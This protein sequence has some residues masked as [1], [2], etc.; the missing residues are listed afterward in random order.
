MK[1]ITNL[2]NI[3]N[4]VKTIS[5][6]C[7]VNTPKILIVTKYIGNN[8]INDIHS[9]DKK[10]HFGENY[11]D[12]LIEK[13]EQL[14]NSIKWHFIG[15]LQSNKC[16]NILKV[17]NLYMIESID[18]EKKA[19]LLNNYL[20]IINEDNLNTNENL[21]KIR[22]LIQIKT[23]DDENKTGIIHDNYEEI[24]N[25]VLYII[26]N[27]NFLIF[28]GLMTISSLEIS[29]RENSFIILNNIK[30]RL[31]N[32]KTINNYFHKKKFHMSMG[33]SDDLELAIKHQTTQLRIGRAIFK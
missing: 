6:Q 22:V 15:N 23:A 27:C 12:S 24:E 32:N 21:K 30:N 20:K 7:S 14:P 17:K 4:K 29:K 16:K 11:L 3:E 9:Y 31:L 10:Y 19:T 28:K 26:Q 2:K 8:E 18:K 5:E 25:I 33:M 13:S 1:Y